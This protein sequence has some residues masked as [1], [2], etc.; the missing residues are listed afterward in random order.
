MIPRGAQLLERGHDLLT[1]AAAGGAD[2]VDVE[3]APDHRRGREHLRGRLRDGVEAGLNRSRFLVGIVPA[4]VRE[5]AQARLD[6]VS[7][8]AAQVLSAA[9]VIGRTFDVDTVR[10]ASGRSGEEVVAALEELCARVITV[11]R[12]AAYETTDF[13][14][15]RVRA[16]VDERSGLARRRLLNGRVAEA[17]TLRHGDPA[18]TARR[19]QLAGRADEAAAAYAAA[20]DRARSLAAGAEALTHYR[21]ALALGHPQPSQ[22]HE[23]IGDIHTLRGEY[24]AALAAYDTRPQPIRG[25]SGWPRSSTSW[26]ACTSAGASGS[27]PSATCRRR[28]R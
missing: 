12:D 7:E 2:G 5:L 21:S 8:T 26:G 13:G 24:A 22:L 9:A 1:G 19:S 16:A 23:A 10:A 6:A 11:E 4:G 20:G 15:E 18:L 3:G 14:H 17:L 27:W 28:L 25:P